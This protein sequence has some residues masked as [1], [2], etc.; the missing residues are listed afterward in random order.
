MISLFRSGRSEL[1]L[2]AEVV[3]MHLI[4]SWWSRSWKSCLWSYLH[5]GTGVVKVHDQSL[6]YLVNCY[7]SGVNKSTEVDQWDNHISW[8]LYS[9]LSWICC[10][11][12]SAENRIPMGISTPTADLTTAKLLFDST[13][14][15][16]TSLIPQ[17][18]HQMLIFEHA[19]KRTGIHAHTFQNHV[20]RI[21]GKISLMPVS[22]VKGGSTFKS[23]RIYMVYHKLD[24]WPTSYLNNTWWRRASITASLPPGCGDVSGSQSS[25]C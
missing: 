7:I 15:H 1:R 14:F 18:W 24:C 4:G 11:L 20:S 5:H 2:L 23:S 6:I 3:S 13:I 25:L 12:S 10:W 22:G 9:W 21:C 19:L 8:F 17:R 16:L